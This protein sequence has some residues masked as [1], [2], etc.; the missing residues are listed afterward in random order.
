MTIYFFNEISMIKL[1]DKIIVVSE[2]Q[3]IEGSHKHDLSNGELLN[4]ILIS[5]DPKQ[6][7]LVFRFH[8]FRILTS[9]IKT[10]VPVWKDCLRVF[11]L[12]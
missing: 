4:P 12:F 8:F 5:F 11:I 2:F 3:V 9:Y 7:S 1:K 6:V 10:Q